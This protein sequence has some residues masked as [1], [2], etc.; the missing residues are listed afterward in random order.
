MQGNPDI[1]AVFGAIRSTAQAATGIAGAGF[2]VR[3]RTATGDRSYFAQ[4]TSS[5]SA[6]LSAIDTECG[7]PCGI[8]VRPVAPT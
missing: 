4:D 6:C 7:A 1:A 3:V 5:V 2:H 8:T